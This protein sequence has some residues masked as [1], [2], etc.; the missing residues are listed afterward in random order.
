M[1]GAAI[2]L[3][4]NI[5]VA[6]LFCLAFLIIAANHKRNTAAQWFAL[7][8][9]FAIAYFLF[10][11]LLP[12][13]ADPRPA[14]LAGFA[15][16]LLALIA[17]VIGVA[18]RYQVVVPWTLLGVTLSLALIA[19]WAGLSLERSSLLRQVL[20][21]APFFI[22]CALASW[23][24]LRAR[25]RNRIDRA[26]FG[27]MALSALYYISKP[28]L[29]A[30]VGGVGDRPQAYANT[31]YALYS[32]GSG[33]VLAVASGLAGL[34]ILTRDMLSDATEASRTD[35]L[36][37]LLNRRGFEDHAAAILATPEGQTAALVVCDLDYFKTVND[38]FGHQSGDKV[39]AEFAGHLRAQAPE[40]ALCCRMGGEEFAVL[41]PGSTMVLGRLYA[42][43]V[44]AA[45]AGTPIEGLGSERFTASFGVTT[46]RRTDTLSDMLRRADTALYEA[47]AAGRDR[48]HMD[49]HIDHSAPP[50]LSADRA[51]Q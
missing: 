35:R 14:Y 47:K 23:L 29:A 21:Q 27:L 5:A 12:G 26:F 50:T 42:E 46:R 7:G 4:I 39:I 30:L 49:A 31:A 33:A 9:G 34:L 1:S 15:A 24:I 8:Y 45:F 38:S 37:G 36:S 2:V 25:H 41:L 48:V 32:Q 13:Q 22:C 40:G 17:S 44:R 28:F 43:A 6:G 16:F 3:A 20:Y 10:E 18:Q 11:F 19:N 51:G